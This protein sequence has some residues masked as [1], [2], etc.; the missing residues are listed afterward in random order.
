VARVLTPEELLAELDDVIRTMPPG[1]TFRHETPENL[2]WF[3]R[4]AAA[5]HAWD[6][7]RAGINFQF[8]LDKVHHLMAAP[9]AEGIRSVIVMLHQARSE[10]ALQTV[11]PLAVAIPHGQRYEYFEELRRIIEAAKSDLFFVDPYLDAEFAAR[12]LPQVTAGVTVRLLGRD[13][14]ASL[15]PAVELQAPPLGLTVEV[16]SAAGFHD[17]YVFADRQ[18][19]YQSGASFKDG[20][21][22]APTVL[23]QIT[24]AFAVVLTDYERRW[25]A[26]T[27]HR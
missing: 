7:V 13:R 12:Y 19:C 20:A 26:A 18:A 23:S 22:N 11:G 4:A 2:A 8:A 10:L 24:D 16:R 1:P 3:G 25:A 27:V 9:A 14:I 15:L 17:R 5:M 21:K 6:P